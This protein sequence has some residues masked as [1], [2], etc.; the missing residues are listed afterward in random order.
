MDDEAHVRR[1]RFNGAMAIA[2]LWV[3]L[4][5]SCT[6]WLIGIALFSGDRMAVAMFLT[7]APAVGAWCVLPGIWMWRFAR[8]GLPELSSGAEPFSWGMV[9]GVGV[10]WA[11]VLW[12]Q[13][14]VL[15]V[16]AIV[17]AL[18]GG[19]SSDLPLWFDLGYRVAFGIVLFWLPG[20]LLFATALR[21]RTV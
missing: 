7:L 10:V 8:Q 14:A 20:W 9:R 16:F 4:S 5:G 19:R 3:L 13:G 17:G 12:A 21:R 11:I 15:I 1:L 18:Q 2:F 6:A